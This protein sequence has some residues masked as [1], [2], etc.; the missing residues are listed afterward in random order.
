LILATNIVSYLDEKGLVL[1]GGLTEK[2]G[3]MHCLFEGIKRK[4]GYYD[5]HG[6]III[7]NFF[8]ST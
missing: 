2:N 3:D 8:M 7:Q 1:M 6:E 4:M 5:R